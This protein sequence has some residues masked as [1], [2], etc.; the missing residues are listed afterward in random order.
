[1]SKLIDIS[2]NKQLQKKLLKYTDDVAAGGAMGLDPIQD[3]SRGE[4]TQSSHHNPKRQHSN[5][6]IRKSAAA[7]KLA[8]IGPK[9]SKKRE[10]SSASEKIPFNLNM[11]RA[12]S[13]IQEKRKKKKKAGPMLETPQQ[14]P[15]SYSENS[16]QNVD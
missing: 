4:D 5:V 1:M 3:D 15:V 6:K 9:A 14:L 11:G 10:H 12:A 7:G 13:P 2:R 16:L 8:P